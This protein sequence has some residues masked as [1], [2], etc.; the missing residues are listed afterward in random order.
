MT[1]T[2]QFKSGVFKEQYQYRSFSPSF[3]NA[4]FRW[5][6]REIDVLLSDA[7]RYL[8][9][10]NAY[11]L[12]IPDVNFF[13]RMHVLK[14]VTTSSRIE[15]TKTQMDEALL[16]EEEVL[17]EQKED[18][19]EVQ[20]YIKAMNFAVTE[21]EK[22][23][24]SMRL[25]N[26]IHKILLSGVRGKKKSP[27]EIRRSQNWIGGSNLSNAFFT[28]PAQDELPDLLT[29]L[30]KFIYNETLAMPHLIKIAIAHY[31]FETIHPYLDGNGRIG[32]LLIPLY[33]IGNGLLKKPT[34]YLSEFFEKNKGSYY[35]AL[36]MV[37]SS[38]NMEQWIKFFLT[39]MIETAQKGKS[40]LEAIIILKQV[41]EDKIVTMKQRAKNAGVLLRHLYI[42]PIV[43]V[44]EVSHHLKI[45]HQTANTLVKDFQK[46]GILREITGHR[47][48]RLFIFSEYL[49]LFRKPGTGG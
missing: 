25:L 20:N 24:I 7:N 6:D 22:L 46:I 8:G 48:N 49:A 12:L 31:Q 29:D 15:G 26:R 44:I 40:T 43:N 9:E 38:N 11:S 39:G 30:E 28:P 16:P 35:D 27:G 13:I 21:L 37:R 33:L 32:R 42:N 23:P 47:R 3:V 45:T 18:W 41:C 5:S 4:P 19:K 34:L 1:E 10:L 36:T 2:L 17:P 14:E